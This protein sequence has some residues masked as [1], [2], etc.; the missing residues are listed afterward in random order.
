MGDSFFKQHW[1]KRKRDRIEARSK[2]QIQMRRVCSRIQV[3]VPYN[4]E[5]VVGA[6]KLWGRWR[7]R[8][9]MWSFSERNL[10]NVRELIQQVFKV[11]PPE[12]Q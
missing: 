3:S 11:E 9:G 2:G 4:P 8:S 1:D 7:T 12:V 10:D 6:K 5:F